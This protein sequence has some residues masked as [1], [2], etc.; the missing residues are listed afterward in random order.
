MAHLK[1]RLRGAFYGTA[2]GDALGGPRQFCERDEMPLL[3][4]MKPIYNFKMPAGCWSDDTSMMLC[5]A[6]SLTKSCY[7]FPQHSAE[8]NTFFPYSYGKN[9]PQNLSDQLNLYLHWFKDGYNT[10]TGK[11]F[12]VGG[13]TKR[14]MMAFSATGNIIANTSD[15]M[16]QGNGSIM[17]LA[18]IAMMFYDDEE[19]AANEAM[20]SSQTTHT[21][22]VCLQACNLLARA[23]V[24][25][26]QGRSKESVL[27]A[28]S[29]EHFCKELECITS[30]NYQKKTR[31]QIESHGWVVATLEAALWC[32]YKTESFEDGLILAV[33]LAHDA[34]T[35]GAVYG[36]L[37]GAFYGFTN[38]PDRWLVDL[39]GKHILD[40]IYSKFEDV[41]LY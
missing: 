20:L 13:T 28:V 27:D 10:P 32:F 26:L 18:P 5:L 11:T 41:I 2:V 8:G 17:R 35:V 33:N 37:A 15:D 25:A 7:G 36:A 16:F 22:I 14:A 6:E 23:I 4:E 24:T 21:N 34:D 1:D 40:S 38:I 9:G 30:G 3:T 29:Q 39:K 12:D 31:K 19:R